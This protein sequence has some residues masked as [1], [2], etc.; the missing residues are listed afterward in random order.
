MESPESRGQSILEFALT[1]PIFLW[2]VIGI[3]DVSRGVAAYSLLGNCARE[4]ARAAIFP[5]TTDS[6]IQ[7]AVNSET[8]FLGNVPG[9]VTMQITP[10]GQTSR[11]SGGTI[12]VTLSYNYSPATPILSNLVGNSIALTAQSTMAIE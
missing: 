9:T 4:G 10:A 1:L 7:N 5:Q 8:L 6:V 3:F 2:I 11:V 12:T